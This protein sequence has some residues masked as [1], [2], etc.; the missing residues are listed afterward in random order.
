MLKMNRYQILNK[1]A[2]LTQK[3]EKKEITS[4]EYVSEMTKLK[5]ELS[6][7]EKQICD[8]Y[9]KVVA[10]NNI[11]ILINHKFC[12]IIVCNFTTIFSD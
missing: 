3:H 9:D 11:K 1:Q 4:R 10:E 12:W 8:D 6:I 5:L 2:T 7:V